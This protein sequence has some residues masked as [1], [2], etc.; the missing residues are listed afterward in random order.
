MTNTLKPRGYTGLE[1]QSCGDCLTLWTTSYWKYLEPWWVLLAILITQN[2]YLSSGLI[3][4]LGFPFVAKRILAEMNKMTQ[5]T[6][7]QQWVAQKSLLH[8]AFIPMA[9][10]TTGRQKEIS[11]LQW[12]NQDIKATALMS[13]PE[14]FGSIQC[15]Y[16]TN[17]QKCI[18]MN[19]LQQW[20][21]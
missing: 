9:P 3:K 19:S 18:R 5:V 10:K 21:H 17:R 1:V 20:T 7:N 11:P 14:L 15:K 13:E 16:H 2:Q 4:F 8:T 6:K 12:N